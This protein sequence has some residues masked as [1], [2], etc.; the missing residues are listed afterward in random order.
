MPAFEISKYN[1]EIQP[2]HS[3]IEVVPKRARQLPCLRGVVLFD[4][5]LA[6]MAKVGRPKEGWASKGPFAAN[7]ISIAKIATSAWVLQQ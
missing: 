5:R 6:L 1:T 2:P 4:L 3:Q 7:K